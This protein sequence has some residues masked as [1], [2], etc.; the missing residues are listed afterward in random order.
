MDMLGLVKLVAYF[1]EMEKIAVTTALSSFPQFRKGRRP[2]RVHNLLKNEEQRSR[3]DS[4][5]E[6]LDKPA[7]KN[8]EYEGG[9][10]LQDGT[11]SDL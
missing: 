5:V 10:G 4:K 6:E 8:I 9:A 3:M 2:I 1:D 11:G 7:D